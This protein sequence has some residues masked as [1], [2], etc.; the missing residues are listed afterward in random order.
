MCIVKERTINL[1][2]LFQ[3]IN[4]IRLL[5]NNINHYE[6]IIPFIQN[7]SNL[8]EQKMLIFFIKLLKINYYEST[9][10]DCSK[11]EKPLIEFEVNKNHAKLISY[12]KGLLKVI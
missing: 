5:R 9:V 2:V 4:Y 12:L 6:P 10:H 11:I 1:L 3:I 7:L 8:E